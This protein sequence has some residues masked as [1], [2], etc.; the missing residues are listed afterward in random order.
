M[1]QASIAVLVAV[2]LSCAAT[3]MLAQA[4]A[5]APEPPVAPVHKL[6]LTAEQRY[7]IREIIKD[8]KDKPTSS[9]KGG[10]RRWEMLRTCWMTW[11]RSWL[12]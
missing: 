11:S 1:R 3:P 9:S 10:C 6:N 7:T 8:V 2:L 5:P 4:P 12:A